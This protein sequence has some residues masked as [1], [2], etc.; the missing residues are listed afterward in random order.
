MK[1]LQTQILRFVRFFKKHISRKNPDLPYYI[2]IFLAFLV[3]VTGMNLFVELT[4]EVG[5]ND[6]KYY[7]TKIFEYIWSFRSPG[8][9]R[10]FL[11]ITDLGSFWAYVTATII[12]A[13]FLFWKFRHWKFVLQLLLVITIAGLSNQFLKEV[14]QRA[15]PSLENMLISVETLS[16]PSGHAMCAMSYYGFLI[17]LVFHIKMPKWLRWAIFA[18]LV[19]LIGGI[20]LSRIYLGVH[21][22]SDVAGGYIAGLIWLMFCIVLFTVIAIWRRRKAHRDPEEIERNLE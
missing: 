13:V 18:L 3:I 19:F 2:L 1:Y 15:R 6:L 14:F 12:M 21:Y 5:E 16:Y 10:F 4:D 20:G 17:Y 22:A 9:N 11:F 8:L 7:D